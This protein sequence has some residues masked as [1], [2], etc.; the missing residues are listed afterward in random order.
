MNKL[1]QQFLLDSEAKAFDLDHRKIL[2]FNISRYD[3]AVKKGKEQYINLQLAKDRAARIKRNVVNNLEEYLMEFE[4]NFIKNGGNLIW[5]I[6]ADEAIK[7]VLEIVKKHNVKK[8]VKS[9]SM[10]TE[11]IEL[12]KHLQAFGVESLET[13]LGEYIV[14]LA[15]EPPYHIVTPA[16]HKSKED[17]AQLYNENFNTPIEYTPEQLTE[18]TRHKLREKF[19][20][21]DMGITGGNFL[22]ADIGGVALTENEGNAALSMAMP[23]IHVAIVGLEKIIPS[24]RDADLFWSLLSTHGTGQKI[25]VYNSIITGSRFEGETDGPDH[26]YLILLD[27]GRTE[28]LA[29]KDQKEALSCIRCGA[30]LNVCPVYKNIGGHAYNAVY[31]GPIGSIIMPHLQGFEKYQH[32]SFASTLC[33]RC[34]EE[35]PV[36]I[37]IHELLLYNRRDAVKQGHTDKNFDRIMLA[38]KIAM[39]KRWII[40]TFKPKLKNV[41]MNIAFKKSW[42]SRRQLPEFKESFNVRWKRERHLK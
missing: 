2:K 10:I 15:D 22:I 29:Q 13:D 40:E 17:I 20:Q 9:K 24:F 37:P 28:L 30:C 41:A 26:M 8:V 31:S 33:G 19:I 23:N 1:Q 39:K 6:D 38:Y 34:S 12:N 11:E 5:A 3:T 14:Q 42:G 32:L 21:A 7:E 18:F 36:N 4:S 27:N 25:T 16:M 35:C